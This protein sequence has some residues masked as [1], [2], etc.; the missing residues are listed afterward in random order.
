MSD[1]TFRLSTKGGVLVGLEDMSFNDDAAAI[2]HARAY[3]SSWAFEIWRGDEFILSCRPLHW[4]PG[5]RKLDR[6]SSI[7]RLSL[8]LADAEAA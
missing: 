8:L 5:S 3:L 6:R 2:E 4:A 7:Y 1:Y